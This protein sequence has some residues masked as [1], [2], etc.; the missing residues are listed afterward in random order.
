MSTKAKTD[1]VLTGNHDGWQ[2]LA[3]V[4]LSEGDTQ[5]CDCEQTA[6]TLTECNTNAFWAQCGDCSHESRCQGMEAQM[7]SESEM[8]HFYDPEY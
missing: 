2:P 4:D 3:D 6:T 5:C 1:K 8:D 7:Q